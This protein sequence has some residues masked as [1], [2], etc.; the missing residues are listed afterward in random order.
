MCGL[1]WWPLDQ[2]I[3]P[4]HGGVRQEAGSQASQGREYGQ[5]GAIL[6]GSPIDGRVA[7]SQPE[8][9]EDE[10]VWVDTESKPDPDELDEFYL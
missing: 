1:A 3:L 6:G 10:T 9:I 8:P 2:P 4:P 7:M 5:T